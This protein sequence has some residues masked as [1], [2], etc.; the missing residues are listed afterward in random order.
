MYAD[1]KSTLLLIQVINT[2]AN[3]NNKCNIILLP[4]IFLS[5]SK[6]SSILFMIRLVKITTKTNETVS[7]EV[8]FWLNE[9]IWLFR[10]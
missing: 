4:A 10:I 3:D 1:C 7:D 2:S 9:R 6:M 5:S 8:L